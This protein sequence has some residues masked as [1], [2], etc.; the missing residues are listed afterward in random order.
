M[1]ETAST[2]F[3]TLPEYD[4][5]PFIEALGPM[6][7][8]FA[9]IAVLEET[10]VVGPLERTFPPHLRRHC[11]ARV[12]RWVQPRAC[13]V[14]LA[15]TIDVLLRQGYVGRDPA[16]G[17]HRAAILDAADRVDP[18][19]LAKPSTRGVVSTAEGFLLVGHPGM[20]KSVTLNRIVASYPDAV[21][22]VFDYAVLTQVPIVKADMPY[23]GSVKGFCRDLILQIGRRVGQEAEYGDLYLHSRATVDT[24]TLDIQRLLQIHAVGLLIVDEVQHLLQSRE[25]PQQLMNFLTTLTNVHGVPV[26]LVGTM[27][28]LDVVEEQFRV[29]RR[30]VGEPQWLRLDRGDDWEDFVGQLWS[31]QWTAGRTPLTTE[32]SECLYDESQGILDVAVKLFWVAQ[33]TAIW[34]G[35]VGEDPSEAITVELVRHVAA[36]GFHVIQPMIAALRSRRPEKLIGFRDLD[37]LRFQLGPTLTSDTGMTPERFLQLRRLQ[38]ERDEASAAVGTQ[39]GWRSDMAAML[40]KEGLGLDVA[41][42]LLDE[43]ERRHPEGGFLARMK[44]LQALMEGTAGPAALDPASNP[45]PAAI[46]E[47]QGRPRRAE[48]PGKPSA[49]TGLVGGTSRG[50]VAKVV[51]E[52]RTRPDDLRFLAADARGG[53]RDAHAAFVEAAVCVSLEEHLRPP[54]GADGVHRSAG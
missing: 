32:L 30:S 49:A 29:A 4:G 22:H 53:G 45:A 3:P 43:V 20:G 51:A 14:E 1:P 50:P 26:V 35:E 7:D 24:M 16:T 19:D 36:N 5:N 27:G 33:R 13:Q 6:R 9:S 39:G 52:G 44:T 34:K 38:A 17:K 15:D 28:A 42:A 10:P 47:K 31:F 12:L 21:R 41:A 48:R 2:P 25:S 11:L 40:S 54:A 46:E 37:A 18:E 23:L 8:W